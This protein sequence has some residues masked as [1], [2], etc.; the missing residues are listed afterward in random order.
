MGYKL[1][2][3]LLEVCDCRVLCPCWVGEDPDNGTCDSVL[4]YHF[5]SG[6]IDGVEVSGLTLAIAGHI[7]GNVLEGNFRVILFVDERASSEQETALL[8]VY[9]GEAGGPIAEF[10]QLFGEIV[11]VRRVP[12]TFTVNEG[13][14]SLR[15]GN[16]AAAE[17][18]PFVGPTG[19]PTTLVESIFSTI[20][21]SPAYVGKASSFELRCRELGQDLDLRGHNAIQGVFEYEHDTVVT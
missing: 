17:L 16:T 13:K 20:P 5:D 15:V 10:V 18:E 11:A 6:E 19:Q 14:G 1:A 3:R 9:R 8:R 2:G 12:I 4:A 7:P 21:G